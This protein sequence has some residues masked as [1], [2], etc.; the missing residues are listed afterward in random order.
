MWPRQPCTTV[1]AVSSPLPQLLAF[2]RRHPVAV[3]G[4][5]AVSMTLLAV[6]SANLHSRD[7]ARIEPAFEVAPISLSI[8]AMSLV[9]LP[10][11]VRR[12]FPLVAVVLA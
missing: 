7:L 1:G 3:D 4:L 10:L 8:A 2:G 6:L 11:A 5:A 12:R 9:T